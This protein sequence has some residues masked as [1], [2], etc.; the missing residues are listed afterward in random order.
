MKHAWWVLAALALGVHAAQPAPQTETGTALRASELKQKPFADADKVA[1][2]PEKAPLD[3]LARQGA[4]MQVK[5][6]DG[7]TGWVKMLNVRTGSG[8]IKSGSA[9][10]GLSSA[11]SMFRTG[12]SGT[13]V[14]TGVKGLSEEDLKNAQPNPADLAKLDTYA[15]SADEAAKFA[16][17]AKLGAKADIA[18]LA[19]PGDTKGAP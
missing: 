6:K 15:T 1:D 8:E 19:K 14:T 13:T 18:Y 16:K 12:S 2:I 9:S 4:W 3:I 11:L 5:T 7:Q 17:A 10:G